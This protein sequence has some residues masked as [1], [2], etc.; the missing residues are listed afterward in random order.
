LVCWQS[1]FSG[2]F[3]RYADS[4]SQ[5][6][7]E[8]RRNKAVADVLNERGLRIRNGSE[9]SD[10]TGQRLIQDPIAKGVR[11]IIYSKKTK[12]GWALKPEHDWIAH[13]D[14]K[15]QIEAEIPKAEA[16][17]A[18]IKVDGLSR[19]YIMEE[20]QDL[21]ACWPT[22]STEEKRRIV[23]MLVKSIDIGTDEINFTLCHLPSFSEMT[24]R[25][26]TLRDSVPFCWVTLHRVRCLVTPY[27]TEKTGY[28]ASSKTIGD[29]IRKGRLDPGLSPD[30]LA[31]LAKQ[32]PGKRLTL[33]HPPG[34][35]SRHRSSMKTHFR[36]LRLLTLLAGAW[37]AP[38]SADE[39]PAPD[40]AALRATI[41]KSLGFLA[42][43]GD[44]WVANKDCNACH[45]MPGLLWSHREAQLRG[46]PVDQQKFE[47]W[48][49]WSTDRAAD[50]KPAQQLAEVALMILALPKRPA[51]ELVKLIAANQQPDGSWPLPAQDNNMKNGGF[52]DAQADAARLFLLALA[53]PGNT[54]AETEAARMKSAAILGQKD[55]PKSLH[56]L[57][58]RALYA[59][60]FGAP[61][62][63]DS[64]RT[65]ILQKQ[66]GDGGWSWIIGENQSDP[67]ATGEVL[68][69]LQP[70]T[71]PHLARAIAR[72]QRWLLAT[73]RDDGSWPIDI[74]HI[75]KIDRSAPAM[76]K[77][78]KDATAIYTYWGSAWAT[79]GLLQAIPVVRS[80]ELER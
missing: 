55:P 46:F 34:G 73:Q 45:H 38:A 66:R 77:V 37:I 64:L 25:Q 44:R 15:K 20:A 16:D 60:R 24:N 75:S 33:H 63:A 30:C 39:A 22:M 36:L 80:A 65:E 79:I 18:L 78:L 26:R 62:E 48:L 1:Y 51:P 17:L 6:F 67:L 42:T 74:S 32:R 53:T 5:L 13:D 40:E 59:Q 4:N 69:A 61:G 8:H 29:V 56:S 2:A 35:S 43:E 23:E 21:H 72:A 68:Y 70:S 50:V 71:D 31:I 57:V 9:W 54:S 58:Y 19:E 3:R 76:S 28:P 47:S 49:T 14:R 27:L 12:D 11:R 41:T 7:A 52:G 10:T